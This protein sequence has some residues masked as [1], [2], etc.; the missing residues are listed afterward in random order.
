MRDRLNSDIAETQQ[1]QHK[2]RNR[3]ITQIISLQGITPRTNYLTSPHPRLNPI[4]PTSCTSVYFPSFFH[5]SPLTVPSASWPT[6]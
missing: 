5:W 2:D 1:I 6:R 3:K 4:F